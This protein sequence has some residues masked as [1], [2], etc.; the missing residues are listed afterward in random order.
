MSARRAKAPTAF[1]LAHRPGFLIRRL[2]QIHTALFIEECAEFNVTPVQ[3]SVM[4]AIVEQSALEQGRIAHEVG[5]D[6]ATLANVVARLEARGLLRRT[7]TKTDRRLKRVV[8]TAKGRRLLDQ[9]A[10]AARRAHTRTIDALP[11]GQRAAFLRAL[12]QLV[13]AGNDFGRAPLSLA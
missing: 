7:T 8:L 1:D 10:Q 11:P 13:E 6:R 12:A 2:H 3:Y 4:T 5:V 9:M